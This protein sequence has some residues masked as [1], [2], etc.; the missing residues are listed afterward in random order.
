MKKKK[1]T[2]CNML[3]YFINSIYHLQYDITDRLFEENKTKI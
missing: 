2:F 3:Y 1:E